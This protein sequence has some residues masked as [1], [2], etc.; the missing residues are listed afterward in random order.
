M[1]SPEINETRNMGF[2]TT[3]HFMKQLSLNVCLNIIKKGIVMNV[4]NKYARFS[5]AG[6]LLLIAVSSVTTLSA[7]VTKQYNVILIMADDV[8]A[9]DLSLYEPKNIQTPSLDRMGREGMYFRTAWA[10]PICSPSRALIMTG[11]YAS[12]TQV[13]HN[14]IKGESFNLAHSHLT[15]GELM[16]AAGYRTAFGGKVQMEGDIH[17]EYGFDETYEWRDW[18]GYDGPMET[19]DKANGPH[20]RGHTN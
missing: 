17:Q 18:D 12:K 15:F 16:R 6:L 9:K 13:W 2:N 5:L 19:W 10:T 14:N 3:S 20:P 11:K 1:K 4:E 8:S 7:D